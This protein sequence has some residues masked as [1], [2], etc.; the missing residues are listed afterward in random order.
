MTTRV[1]I[2]IS[3]GGSNMRAMAESMTGD[4]PARPA[5]VLSN[6]ADAGGIAWARAQGSTK[7][8]SPIRL[9]ARLR[10]VFREFRVPKSVI[11]EVRRNGGPR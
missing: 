10:P 3:G 5:L 8:A 7:S 11:K 9:A 2:F 6:N 4:H 1:G